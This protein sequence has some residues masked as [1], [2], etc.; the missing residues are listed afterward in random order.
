[1]QGQLASSSRREAPETMRGRRSMVFV[2]K[3]VESAAPSWRERQQ[4]ANRTNEKGGRGSP[5]PAG[6]SRRGCM[7]CVR[8]LRGGPVSGELIA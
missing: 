5:Q 7:F 6:V 1:M 8:Y 3:F 2:C 4:T